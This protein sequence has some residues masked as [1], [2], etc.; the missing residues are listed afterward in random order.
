MRISDWSSD[1][2]S[3]DL[4]RHARREGVAYTAGVVLTCVALGAI[5]LALRAGGSAIGW[6]FQLQDPR[7][8][9]V[10]F[11]LALAIALNLAGLFQIP[12]P[13]FVNRAAGSG[14]AFLAGVLAAFVATPCTGPFMG[15]ALGAALVLPVWAALAVF[16]GLGQI[17]RAHV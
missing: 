15:A 8:I 6:A 17:G 3:S 5:I 13:R 14:G 11:V 16:A 10:L 12:T 4:E 9:V 7:M 1:V 2:C